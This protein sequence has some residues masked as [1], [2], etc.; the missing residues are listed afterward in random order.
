MALF[1]WIQ[2]KMLIPLGDN[3]FS[4]SSFSRFKTVELSRRWHQLNSFEFI[5][6]GLQPSQLQLPSSIKWSETRLGL[7]PRS[8]SNEFL[9]HTKPPTVFFVMS[10]F[11]EYIAQ[12]KVKWKL[13]RLYNW[14]TSN[15][16]WVTWVTLSI[17][18]F[19]HPT[20]ECQEWKCKFTFHF[21]WWRMPRSGGH[22]DFAPLRWNIPCVWTCAC[23]RVCVC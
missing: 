15:S 19:V 12:L 18:P 3:E 7:M 5:A 1:T 2:L 23:V 9:F 13:T 22:Y 21:S 14:I 20:N 4:L 11:H 10:L 17:L 8:H 16:V 6:H